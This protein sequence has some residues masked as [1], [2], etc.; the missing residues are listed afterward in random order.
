MREE[1]YGRLSERVRELENENMSL[2]KQVQELTAKVQDAS[3][4]LERQSLAQENL[5][6]YMKNAKT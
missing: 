4:L 1:E 3:T 2:R 6:W 5:R